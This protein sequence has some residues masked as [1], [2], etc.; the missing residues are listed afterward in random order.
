MSDVEAVVLAYPR[1]LLLKTDN[2]IYDDGRSFLLVCIHGTLPVLYKG[3]QY[4]IPLSVW[5]PHSYPMT[6]PMIFVTPTPNMAVRESNHVDKSGKI[7]HTYL[8]DWHTRTEPARIRHFLS[9]L[10][11]IFSIECPV[12]AKPTQSSSSGSSS[13]SPQLHHSPPHHSNSTGSIP[14]HHYTQQQQQQ[15]QRQ[16][17]A[18]DFSTASSNP[19]H[20]ATMSTSSPLSPVTATTKQKQQQLPTQQPDPTSIKLNNSKRALAQKLSTALTDLQLKSPLDMDQFLTENRAL[21][22]NANNVAEILLKY[23]DLE[24]RAVVNVE[25]LNKTIASIKDMTA[26][27]EKEADLPPD[28]IVLGSSVVHE[29]FLEASAAEEALGDCVYNVGSAFGNGKLDSVTF[30]KI[31]RDLARQRFK[32]LYLKNKINR[33]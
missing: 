32:K 2:F 22:D 12:Y 13:H 6:S 9:I 11:E 25:S 8:N 30:L 29:Q 23:R 31:V 33:P 19:N 20:S 10:Q 18:T 4:H 14:T 28:E 21:N 3:A 27:L 16:Y 26:N 1:E 15:Q 24:K 5:I 7:Y 17:S